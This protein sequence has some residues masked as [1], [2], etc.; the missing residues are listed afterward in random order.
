MC[1]NPDDRVVEELMTRHPDMISCYDFCRNPNPRA[2]DWI[3]ANFD[4]LG[5]NGVHLCEMFRHPYEPSIRFVWDRLLTAGKYS[6]LASLPHNPHPVAKE[7]IH[8]LSEALKVR[9]EV[10]WH[11]FASGLVVFPREEKGEENTE[12]R[13][14]MESILC[15]L[16]SEAK[17]V[18]FLLNMGDDDPDLVMRA[19]EKYP[20]ISK[21]CIIPIL[22]AL[23]QV[24]E[25]EF[26]E[27]VS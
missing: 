3:I 8:N 25:V 22:R 6:D 27:K 20:D 13:E 2:Q 21:R 1:A 12:R 15:D 26:V 14:S 18:Y 19:V 11:P 7:L 23:C 4:R 9:K 5:L 17:A 16:D 10:V 24:R